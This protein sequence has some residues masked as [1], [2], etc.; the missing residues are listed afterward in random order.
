MLIN[1]LRSLL[2]K[3]KLISFE[4]EISIRDNRI[5][6]LERLVESLTGE[7]N[8]LRESLQRAQLKEDELLNKI[9]EL[10]GVNKKSSVIQDKPPSDQ[11][12]SMGKRGTPWNQVRAKLEK[13]SLEAYW[14]QKKLE[15]EEKNKEGLGIEGIEDANK[16]S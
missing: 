11:F 6:D 15:Q 1:F 9:F 2:L 3:D 4:K 16:V 10:T 12:I 13:D 14:Q 5:K 7:G 8:I